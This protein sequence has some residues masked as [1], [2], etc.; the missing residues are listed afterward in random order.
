M[1]QEQDTCLILGAVP[2]IPYIVL[3]INNRGQGN[4][5]NLLVHTDIQASS[6]YESSPLSISS[7]KS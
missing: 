7:Y 5:R 6:E 4:Y 2:C 3:Q 1:G